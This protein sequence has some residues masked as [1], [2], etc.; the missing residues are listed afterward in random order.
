MRH[1]ARERRSAERTESTPRLEKPKQTIQIEE[2][3]TRSADLWTTVSGFESLPP[4]Q[5]NPHLKFSG[6]SHRPKAL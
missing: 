1:A 6:K 4:S 3:A 2:H 5:C